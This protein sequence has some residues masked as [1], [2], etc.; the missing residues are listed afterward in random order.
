[1]KRVVILKPLSK[2]GKQE[3]DYYFYSMRLN[4]PTKYTVVLFS[5]ALFGCSAP[6]TFET[7][8]RMGEKERTKIISGKKAARVVNSMH[9]LSVAPDASVIVEYGQRKKDVLY[10]SRYT[11]REDAHQSLGLMVGK[12]SSVEK[13]PFFHLIQLRKYK[14]KVYMTFGMGAIHYIYISD[15]SILWLQS[16][17]SFGTVLPPQL[18][19]L[20]PTIR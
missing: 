17:Q 19:K 10:I 2:V 3:N 14:H 4:F 5:L 8:E 16:Y 11:N 12:I 9:G 1:M 7:P 18:V 13:G 15:N 20:Y 6:T